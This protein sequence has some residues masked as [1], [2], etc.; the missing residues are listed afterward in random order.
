MS[1]SSILFCYKKLRK[2]YFP[3]SLRSLSVEFVCSPHGHLGSPGT[4]VPSQPKAVH[5][6]RVA[7]CLV[8][9]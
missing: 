4:R 7:V 3:S 1:F 2:K 8:P 9:V 6:R 5:V